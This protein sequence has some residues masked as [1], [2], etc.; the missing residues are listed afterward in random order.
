MDENERFLTVN[1]VAELF[2]VNPMTVRNWIARGELT[3]VRL[4]ARRVR[5][6][7]SDLAA[8]IEPGARAT[9][10]HTERTSVI[11]FRETDA[12]IE[13]VRAVGPFRAPMRQPSD[14]ATSTPAT[15]GCGA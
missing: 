2:R 7:Q 8:F 9:R 6:R 14:G 12:G 15:M 3:G 13:Y 4:G 1:E 10:P 11:E 5:V